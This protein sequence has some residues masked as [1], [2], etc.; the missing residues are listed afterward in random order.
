MTIQE[1]IK[2]LR[3]TAKAFD[4]TADTL[5]KGKN[6]T[7]RVSGLYGAEADLDKETIFSTDYNN[8]ILTI[9]TDLYTG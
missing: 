5:F 6:I 7:V 8:K 1:L 4:D 3:E 9:Q 2:R